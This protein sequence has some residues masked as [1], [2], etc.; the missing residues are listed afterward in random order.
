[1]CNYIVAGMLSILAE[2]TFQKRSE[3]GGSGLMG[4]I[5][6][7]IEMYE[8]ETSQYVFKAAVNGE[9]PEGKNK[10]KKKQLEI[11]NSK[12]SL[13]KIHRPFTERKG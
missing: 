7:W 3:R 4:K 1:M 8:G 13:K 10:K 2:M 5:Q 12:T 11:F 6:D 9:R